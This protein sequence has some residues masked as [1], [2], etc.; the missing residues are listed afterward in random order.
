MKKKSLRE[1]HMTTS[2]QDIEKWVIEYA[3]RLQA[4]KNAIAPQAE[5]DHLLAEAIQRLEVAIEE[6]VISQ[7]EITLQNEELIIVQTMLEEQR[8]RYLAL[9]ELAPDAYLVT[10]ASG[11]IQDAN[12]AASALFNLPGRYFTGKPLVTFI[13]KDSHPDFFLKLHMV[14]ET[15]RI[16]DWQLF[17]RPREKSAIPV[18]VNVLAVLDVEGEVA[19]LR[20]L[21]RDMTERKQI[22][23][24]EREQ[25]TLAETL[26]DTA[27]VLNSTL[28]VGLV[29]E[30]ILSNVGRVLPHHA[31]NLMLIEGNAVSVAASHGYSAGFPASD[32]DVDL[33]N[34]PLLR[35]IAE[36]KQPR[37]LSPI[38]SSAFWLKSLDAEWVRSSLIAPILIDDEII[39]FL[40]LDSAISDFFAADCLTRI[41]VFVDQAAIAIRNARAYRNRQQLAVIEERQR[42]A[43]DLHDAVSQT[44][45]SAG[46]IAE[47]LPE[48]WKKNS[49]KAEKKVL[50]LAD[51]IRGSLHE[52]RALLL[53]LLPSAVGDMGLDQ[54]VSRLIAAVK[55]RTEL[56]ID[57]ELR[58]EDYL[59]RNVRETLYRIT[60]EALNNAVRHA[61][62]TQINVKV[63]FEQNGTHVSLSDNG[64]GFNPDTPISPDHYGISIMQERA[65][66]I[67]AVLTIVSRPEQGTIVEVA[68]P[69][70][71]R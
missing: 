45:W 62:A 4:L 69:A 48:L 35:E 49:G 33:R 25:R 10:N 36:S 20:W 34:A 7:E 28:D 1:Q 39:G 51:L 24:V 8:Q 55:S 37:I 6:L 44:M 19:E 61:A 3:P 12:E 31:S 56:N 65:R 23:A 5:Q 71:L 38:P 29:L 70:R 15:H 17:L 63:C 27:A 14:T 16:D 22:E 2:A 58:G 42:I 18:S 53:E 46:I 13:M 43:R 59:P 21:I 52:M 32:V 67:G 47:S 9:F 11:I 54:A 64:R 57:L 66:E 68:Y 30:L 26:V 41:K 50:L 40:N 60:Q